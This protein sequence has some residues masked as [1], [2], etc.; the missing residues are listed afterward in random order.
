MNALT[1]NFNC[2][3]YC[4]VNTVIKGYKLLHGRLGRSATVTLPENIL[5]TKL[6]EVYQ[7][8]Q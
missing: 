8:N 1:S 3:L 6:S 4:Y 7:K 5:G 2:L